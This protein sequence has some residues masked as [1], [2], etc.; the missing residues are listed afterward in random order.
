LFSRKEAVMERSQSRTA[1]S[2]ISVEDFQ[3]LMKTELVQAVPDSWKRRVIASMTPSRLKAGTRFICQGLKGDF[4]Y[5][6]Q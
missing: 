1:D 2:D 4:L 3:F 6:I 5:L